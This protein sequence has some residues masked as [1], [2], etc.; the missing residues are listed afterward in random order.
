[1]VGNFRPREV[2]HHLGY[3]I[4]TSASRTDLQKITSSAFPGY[5]VTVI[6]P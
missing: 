6:Y 2:W 5:Y 4:V 3:A 1:M